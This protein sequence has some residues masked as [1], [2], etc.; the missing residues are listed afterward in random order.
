MQTMLVYKLQV[1]MQYICRF[2]FYILNFE[3]HTCNMGALK[4]IQ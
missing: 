4:K 1:S 2:L 3:M